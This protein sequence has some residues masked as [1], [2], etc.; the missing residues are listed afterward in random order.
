MYLKCNGLKAEKA[1]MKFCKFS[2]GVGKRSSNLA[3]IGELGRYPLFIEIIISMFSYLTRISKSKD[4]LLSEALSVSKL[5]SD[6]NTK[7]WYSTTLSLLKYLKLDLRFVMN[8]KTNLKHFLYTKLKSNYNRLWF[9]S[10]HDDK[11]NKDFGNKLRTYR[12]FKNNIS[13][14][15]Y[16]SMKNDEQ[17]ILLSK[18]RISNHNLEIERGRHRGLQAKERICKLCLKEVEDEI[19]FLLKCEALQNVRTPFIDLINNNNYNFKHLDI[20]EQFIWL[21]SNEDNFIIN[22]LSDMIL[23]LHSSRNDIIQN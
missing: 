15:P 4:I 9:L 18:L 22:Q 14:E 21:M 19:H 10:L 16:L 13:L 2:L 23:K 11:I 8:S 6:Q 3:V 12:L 20:R 17:R 5:L 7:S 1:H